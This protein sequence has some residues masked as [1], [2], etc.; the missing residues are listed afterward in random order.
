MAR[1]TAAAA[2]AP[3]PVALSAVGLRSQPLVLAREQVLPVLPAF[4]GL[5]HR[6]YRRHRG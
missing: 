4:E 1:A 6:C 3:S 2:T 5:F